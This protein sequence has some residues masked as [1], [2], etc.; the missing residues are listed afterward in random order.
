MLDGSKSESL[1][2]VSVTRIGGTF[3]M[4]FRRLFRRKLYSEFDIDNTTVCN[5]I[6]AFNPI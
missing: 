6:L 1:N 5:A 3:P 2:D 4:V